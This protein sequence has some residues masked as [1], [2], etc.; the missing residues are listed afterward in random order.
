MV[1]VGG[2]VS[3][4]LM[5]VDAS[6][7]SLVTEEVRWTIPAAGQT[8][9]DE[10]PIA[11]VVGG[12]SVDGELVL[13]D[14]SGD[15]VAIGEKSEL[16]G[17]HSYVY[18]IER[19]AP[20][21]AGE[22]TVTLDYPGSGR[23]QPYEFGFTVDDDLE[24]QSPP[25]VV[26]FRWHRETYERTAGDSCFATDEFHILRLE[27][28]DTSPAFYEVTFVSEGEPIGFDYI[29][30]GRLDGRLHDRFE[31]RDVDCVRANA[32]AEDGRRGD[33]VEHCTPDR[34]NHFDTDRH[35]GTLGTTDWEEVSGCNLSE[36]SQSH[37]ENGDPAR[38]CSNTTGSTPG[39]LFAI[40]MVMLLA[41]I[42]RT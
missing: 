20:L 26:D 19:D 14:D 15:L 9:V 40:V 16:A 22:Y 13:R 1:A 31:V 36:D 41:G 28:L 29:P 39:L 42:R 12:W 30:P 4:S 6:A 8:V 11:V 10:T 33:V 38:G 37:H 17:A 24:S 27:P 35:H 34:C 2:F 25:G 32:V 3:V 21:D 5:S 23:L 18:E 7:C